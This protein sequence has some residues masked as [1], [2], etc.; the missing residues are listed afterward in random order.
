MVLS[1]DKYIVISLNLPHVGGSQKTICEAFQEKMR[2]HWDT[3]ETNSNFK[4]LFQ[5]FTISK[6]E[7]GIRDPISDPRRFHCEEL[8]KKL[9]YSP[10]KNLRKYP[11][12][13]PKPMNHQLQYIIQ[14]SSYI[15]KLVGGAEMDLIYSSLLVS[16][17]GG[18]AQSWHADVHETH[19]KKRTVLAMIVSLQD[20]TTV[21][22]R[23]GRETIPV[24]IPPGFAMVF[25]AKN[26]IHRGVGYESWNAR[27]YLKFSTKKLST[28]SGESEVTP[29]HTCPG[30]H[31]DIHTTLTTTHTDTCEKYWVKEKKTSKK[32]AKGLVERNIKMNNA[33]YKR[34]NDKKRKAKQEKKQAEKERKAKQEKKQAEKSATK[35]E[36]LKRK[37][38]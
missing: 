35:K 28:K 10:I 23:K 13:V 11:K 4:P 9:K 6:Q 1:I 7:N 32:C 25:D 8:L 27:I 3:P 17:P 34:S 36:T 37:R 2:E 26:L 12:V 16:T 30:C 24:S 31:E 15:A 22:V 19:A 38:W 18:V 29:Q 33:R 14:G 5:K 20:G 21:E